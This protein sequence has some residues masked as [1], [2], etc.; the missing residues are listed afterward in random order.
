MD[1]FYPKEIE[2]II[3]P[4][5]DQVEQRLDASTAPGNLAGSFFPGGPAG[6]QGAAIAPGDLGN[7]PTPTSNFGHGSWQLPLP[8]P[9]N[10]VSIPIPF[11][12]ENL[13][14]PTTNNASE[15]LPGIR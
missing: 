15:V 7:S 10:P 13:N 5:L 9:G 8:A 6:G 1:K 11:T 4:Y 3:R 14:W 2:P 12:A